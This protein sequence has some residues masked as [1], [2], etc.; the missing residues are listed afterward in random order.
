MIRGADIL[1]RTL[2]DL[3]VKCIFTL[4]GNQIMPVFD[5]VIDSGIEL[6]HVRH[7]AAAVHMADAWGRSTGRPGVALVTAG[8]GFANTLS[9]LY[10]ATMAE[11]PLVLISG[12]APN[13]REGRGAF[14]EMTQEEM[15]SYVATST[16]ISNSDLL[17]RYTRNACSLATK[18]RCGPVHISIP[19]DV[20]NAK[21]EADAF[22]D[23]S[24]PPSTFGSNEVES[25]MDALLRA[26]RPMILVGPALCRGE[27][28]QKLQSWEAATHIPVVG[29]ESPRGVND[30]SLG[31][32]AEILPQTDFVLLLG[33]KMDFTLQPGGKVPFDEQCRFAQVDKIEVLE[34]SGRVLDD[35]SPCG[36]RI[37]ADPQRFIASMTGL[38][39]QR[40]WPR[41]SWLDDVRSAIDYRPTEWNEI[42]S[43]GDQPLHAV[44]VCRAVNEFLSHD[45]SSVFVSDG[46]EFGQWA[47]ACVSAR[48]RIINGP[49]GSIGSS[50]PFAL[51][52]RKAFPNSRIVTMLGDGTFGFHPAEFD[53]AVR[54]GLPFVAVVGN[55]AAWNAEHQI[56]LRDYGAER[57]IGCE[58]LPTRYD[59]VARAFGGHGE[60]VTRFEEL[61]PALKR[62][63]QSG[64]PAC[65][66][67]AIQRTAAPVIRRV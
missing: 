23:G 9:A 51:A 59:E 45:E 32:L 12:Q 58:L 48:H 41:S 35:P 2:E 40:K 63:E 26:E 42:R 31:A 49:S 36:Q 47:Q 60:Y 5:A 19:I 52:A 61:A 55:D 28:W 25:V 66:N 6:I 24:P 17:A 44:E 4:S 53:T 14:Q 39:S 10:V 38:A 16:K 22:A 30:P 37:E 34:L 3:G 21:S 7:E 50:I 11:S 8:P 29:M 33:K 65:V 43:A 18:G 46:G 27:S 15:A 54:Y 64:L 56:Q 57:T 13:N 1:V 20:L 62:A 67:V